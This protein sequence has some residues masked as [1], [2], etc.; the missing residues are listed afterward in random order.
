VV[1]I[2][3][4]AGCGMEVIEAARRG[5]SQCISKVFKANKKD[6]ISADF[7]DMNGKT[8]LHYACASQAV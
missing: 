5:D 3:C 4:V 1:I 2:N 8:A 7:K 6:E